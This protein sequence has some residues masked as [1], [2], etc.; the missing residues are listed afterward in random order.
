MKKIIGLLISCYAFSIFA[1]DSPNTAYLNSKTQ[2]AIIQAFINSSVA[3]KQSVNGEVTLS[4]ILEEEYAASLRSNSSHLITLSCLKNGNDGKT[5][6][7][8]FGSLTYDDGTESAHILQ[9]EV[10]FPEYST[11]FTI[12]DI[13]YIMAG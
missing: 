11:D 5:L 12:F 10:Y 8:T 6:K 9:G 13:Q 7:C 3:H 4:E 2:V 1:A